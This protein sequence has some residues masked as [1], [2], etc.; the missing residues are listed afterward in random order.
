MLALCQVRGIYLGYPMSSC[1]WEMHS[2]FSMFNIL[3]LT[4][5]QNGLRE[6]LLFLCSAYFVASFLISGGKASLLLVLL[7]RMSIIVSAPSPWTATPIHSLTGRGLKGGQRQSTLG[8]FC[9]CCRGRLSLL[10]GAQV[11]TCRAGVASVHHSQCA[12]SLQEE[13]IRN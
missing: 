12:H 5:K 8:L 1:R 11:P 7:V 6:I 9:W 3:F 13:G 2:V 10:S 4:P